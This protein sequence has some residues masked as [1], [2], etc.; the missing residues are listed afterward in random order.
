MSKSYKE[1]QLVDHLYEGIFLQKIRCAHFY[2]NLSADSVWNKSVDENAILKLL[3]SKYKKYYEDKIEELKVVLE[4]KKEYDVS[5]FLTYDTEYYINNYNQNSE[6]IN[7]YL[8]ELENKTFE[9]ISKDDLTIVSD[10]L[11]ILFPNF[12]SKPSLLG[13]L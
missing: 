1:Q 9:Q 13:L 2:S 8:V 6:E 3:I 11:T 4:Q 12:M 7:K 10:D 5:N